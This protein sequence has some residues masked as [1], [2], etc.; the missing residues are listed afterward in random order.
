VALE[1]VLITAT[2]NAFERKD[3]AIVDVPG[4]FLMADMDEEVIMCLRRRLAN[5]IVK[6]APYIYHKYICL[7]KEGNSILCVKPHKALCGCLTSALLFCI[8]L[9]EDL[10]SH[11]FELNPYDPCMVNKIIAGK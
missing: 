3:T 10:E 7:D 8:K 6:T 9:V 4:A 5:L 1:S 11:G 2:I